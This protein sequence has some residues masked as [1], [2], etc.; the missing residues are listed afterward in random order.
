[1]TSSPQA[2]GGSRRNRRRARVAPLSL[3][4][5]TISIAV[6]LVAI[7]CAERDAD[8]TTADEAMPAYPASLSS[9]STPSEVAEALIRA[10]D[11]EDQQTLMALVAVKAEMEAIEAIYREHGRTHETD[12]VEAASLAASGWRATYSFLAPGATHVT[13]ED[14][15]VAGPVSAETATVTAS[16]ES[17]A[18]RTPRSLTIRLMREDGVWKV[19]AGLQ[20]A[21]GVP[22]TRQ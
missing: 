18:D 10:L 22:S 1:M 2:Q 19:R 5:I 4:L 7:G 12:P 8:T 16:A 6:T 9:E 20:T 15:K 17:A 21:G 11:E 3:A 13:D 14:I